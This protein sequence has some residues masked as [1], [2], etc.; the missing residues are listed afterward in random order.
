ML[1]VKRKVSLQGLHRHVEPSSGNMLIVLRDRPWWGRLRTVT[2]AV[3]ARHSM[4]RL[5]A[6]QKKQLGAPYCA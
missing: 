6:L 1:P 2:A 4:G 3:S 5:V